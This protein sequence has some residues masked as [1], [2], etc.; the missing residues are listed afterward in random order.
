MAQAPTRSKKAQAE[1]RADVVWEGGVPDGSGHVSAG[2]SGTFADLRVSLPTRV[3]EASGNTSPEEL[4]AASHASC[5]AMAFSLALTGA[6][7]PPQRLSVSANVGLDPKVGGGLEVSFSHLTV[8]G[9]VPGLDQAGFAE[10]ARQAEQNC[11]ISNAIR[12]N[13]EI[14]L[15]ATLD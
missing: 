2:T 12:G 9:T 13:V 5:Y 14:Q 4:L 10:M 15:E 1:R 8:T 7:S 6:G 11:P 3:G